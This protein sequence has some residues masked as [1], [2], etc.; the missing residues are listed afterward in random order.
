MKRV[1]I[2]SYYF[3]PRPGVASLRLRGLAKYLPEFGWE[4]V[5]LTPKLPKV[6]NSKYKVIETPYPGDVITIL[7]H[8]FGLSSDSKIQEQLGIP[9]TL[10]ESKNS[11][12]SKIVNHIKGIIAYP[13]EYRNWYKYAIDVGKKLLENENFDA[14][15]SSYG[16]ATCHLIA[17]ELKRRY[18]IP[19]MAD[20]RDLWT[21]NPYFQ[22]GRI[23]RLFERR[24]EIKT[25][26]LADALVTVSEPWAAK[27]KSLHKNK[28]IFAIPNGYDPEEIASAPLTK[29]F[30]IS[31]TGELYQGKRDPTLL[32]KAIA[33]LISE[34][35]LDKKAIKVRFYGSCEYW[36]E[37]SAKDIGLSD[38]VTLEGKMPRHIVLNKQRESQLLLL[39]LWNHPEEEGTCPA[40]VFEYLAAQRPI[41]AVGGPRG[42]ISE[43]LEETGAGVHTLDYE[44]LKS[45]LLE[46]YRQYKIHGYVPY[47][48]D[49]QRLTKY[50]QFEMARRFA[51][52]L[53]FV[54]TNKKNARSKW[55]I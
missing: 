31:Y 20:F 27:L 2:I 49:N 26:T 29:E 34:G 51:E 15:L 55:K 53:N 28:Y 16:P 24:L 7:K 33:E 1:L 30:T 43:L 22:Y 10:R 42:V 37:R 44:Q 35:L 48:G 23:R 46:L 8:H 3:P 13:D 18:K 41:L 25:I 39:I 52:V 19:W 4:S 17:K 6:P 14:L 36:L 38:V 11:W 21:Q 54:T 32:F 50:S 12:T 47:S 45:V 40:K 9:R 5:I